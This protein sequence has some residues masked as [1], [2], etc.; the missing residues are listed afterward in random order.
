MIWM[1]PVTP[2]SRRGQ[3]TESAR[4]RQPAARSSPSPESSPSRSAPAVIW[5]TRAGESPA[6]AASVR[7]ERVSVHIEP[8][9]V[10]GQLGIGG[11]VLDG[12][13]VGGLGRGRG[14]CLRHGLPGDVE[15]RL[16]D[17]D[18]IFEPL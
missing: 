12:G 6:A 14:R 2:L 17:L 11:A 16:R 18:G 3:R 4:A 8:R 7:I 5:C 15:C 9:E 1:P 13:L 10:L